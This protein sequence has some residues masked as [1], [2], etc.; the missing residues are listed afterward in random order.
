M[1]R[2]GIYGYFGQSPAYFQTSGGRTIPGTGA[3]DR[4]FYRVGA[5]G[6]WYLGKFDFQTFYM[7]GQDNVFL[8]NS[9][10]ANQPGSLPLGAAGPTWNGGFV[11]AHYDYSPRLIL[12]GK[13]E[14]ICVHVR[15]VKAPMRRVETLVVEA[16]RGAWQRHVRN[17]LQWHRFRVVGGSRGCCAAEYRN[18]YC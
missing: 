18:Q 13:Y 17:L 3:G 14:L 10:P 1:Q 5:Y 4:S 9:V 8:G 6:Q 12:I 11:E 7:H 2:I 15:D 16:H